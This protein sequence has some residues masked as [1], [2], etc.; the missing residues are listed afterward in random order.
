MDT[1]CWLIVQKL[2]LHQRSFTIVRIINACNTSTYIHT[3]QYFVYSDPPGFSV[4]TECLRL[5]VMEGGDKQINEILET[6]KTLRGG[7]EQESQSGTTQL[8]RERIM[9]LRR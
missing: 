7:R 2:L 6:H 4:S 8:S 3:Y 5:R 1:K 9:A